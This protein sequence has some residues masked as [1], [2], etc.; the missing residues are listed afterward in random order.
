MPFWIY[1]ILI[2]LIIQRL[3]ELWIAR[4]NEEWMKS[5]GGVEIGEKHY[6]WFVVL[7]AAFFIA[8][9]LEMHLLDHIATSINP[10]LLILFILSQIARAWCIGSLGKYWNT[11]IIILPHA[12]LVTKG[13][14]KFVSHPNYIVVG[15][16]LLIIPL[17][18]GAY[19]S[20]II[21]PFLHILL[22]TVR[23]P[24]EN[25]ALKNLSTSSNTQSE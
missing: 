2:V 4:R 6:K 25:K 20:A 12:N 9:L 19:I 15:L 14:Y 10:F 18:T 17:L 21:F 5:R 11:K 1:I 16:E 8:L 22:L 3:T 24:L 13:P 23:I 7:H